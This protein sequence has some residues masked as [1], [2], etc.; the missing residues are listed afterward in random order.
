MAKTELQRKALQKSNLGY[1][2]FLSSKGTILE[3]DKHEFQVSGTR[4]TAVFHNSRD[5]LRDRVQVD[6]IYIEGPRQDPLTGLPEVAYGEDKEQ[7]FAE[8]ENYMKEQGYRHESGVTVMMGSEHNPHLPWAT[9]QDW[10]RKL[11]EIGMKPTSEQ[12]DE[13]VDA[14]K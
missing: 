12:L 9:R 5:L 2:P 10:D 1:N 4:Y 11:S 13:L 7:I 6:S 3:I 14:L 8:I